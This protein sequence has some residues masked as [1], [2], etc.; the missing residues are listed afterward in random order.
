M[1]L[2]F[3]LTASLAANLKMLDKSIFLAIPALVNIINIILT[4][5][6]N[7]EI[8]ATSIAWQ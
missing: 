4:M 3:V 1:F 5:F 2:D 8:L 6:L 7:S